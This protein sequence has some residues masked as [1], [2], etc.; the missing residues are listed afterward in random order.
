M[1]LLDMKIMTPKVKD[2]LDGIY[3]ILDS[4]KEK[5]CEDTAIETI[6]SKANG[7]KRLKKKIIKH[8]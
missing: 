2:S 7:N 3:N 5:T 8:L 1:E 4:A 6:Q